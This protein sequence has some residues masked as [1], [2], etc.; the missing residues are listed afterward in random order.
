[1]RSFDSRFRR[2]ESQCFWHHISLH[3]G[4]I[5]EGVKTGKYTI[6]SVLKSGSALHAIPS[7]DIAECAIPASSAV[8][9]A[10]CFEE[11]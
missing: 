5:T 7:S 8:M 1:M 6:W 4:H 2:M 11:G 9:W 3:A 10:S